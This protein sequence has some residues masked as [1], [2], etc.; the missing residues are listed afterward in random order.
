PGCRSRRPPPPP[1]SPA[2]GGMRP[3]PRARRA[4]S[5]RLQDGRDDPPE[6]GDDVV[7]HRAVPPHDVP[8]AER[9][10]DRHERPRGDLRVDRAEL[11][12]LDGLFQRRDVALADPVVVPLE[13]VG[14]DERRLAEDAVQAA[15][16]GGELEVA[17]EPEELLLD[18]CRAARR[19]LGHRVA[20][21]AVQVAH[22]LV[23]DVLPRLE[24]EVER[25]LPDPGRLRDLHDRRLV[26]AEL[27]EDVLGRL[28]QL[29][30]RP[31]AARRERAPVGADARHATTSASRP[32]FWILPSELRG[33]SSMNRTASGTLNRASR[34]PHHS[35]SSAS[36]TP[37]ATTNATPHSPQ[38]SC[39]TPTTAASATR[40]CSCS[41]DSTSAGYTFSPPEM[42]MSFNRPL[43][44]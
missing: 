29:L 35:R 30:S 12:L 14:R 18:A 33:T 31:L 24:V 20:D 2:P 5:T 27:A 13:H 42:Y 1:S 34:A 32:C 22:E 4:S 39:G 10:A 40:G 19:L 9:L 3:S 37:S 36:L 38:R 44:R 28:D 41:T 11:A 16:L 23:E 7:R 25:A 26:V 17:G 21:P 43:I 15:V 8:Q 6:L